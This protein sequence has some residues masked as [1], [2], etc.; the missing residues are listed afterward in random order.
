VTL[1]DAAIRSRSI[2]EILGYDEFGL[3]IGAFARFG[4]GQG[5]RAQLNFGDCAMY[6]L[7]ALGGEPVLAT[8]GD[9][10]ATDLVVMPR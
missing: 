9:V 2:D 10:R 1:T 5:H 6:A 7:A 4:K 8:G 3:A